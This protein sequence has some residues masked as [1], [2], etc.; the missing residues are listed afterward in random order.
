MSIYDRQM[1]L[2]REDASAETSC[3]ECGGPIV[4]DE[5]SMGVFVHCNTNDATGYDLDE[6]HVA[7]P[8][9]KQ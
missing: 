2:K 8:D 4:E 5:F 9:N 3:Y 6:A 7:I 1:K